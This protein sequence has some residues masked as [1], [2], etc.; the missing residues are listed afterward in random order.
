MT[1]GK[2]GASLSSGGMTPFTP[3]ESSRRRVTLK[4]QGRSGEPASCYRP[5]T[6]GIVEPNPLEAQ[7]DIDRREPAKAYARSWEQI[8]ALLCKGPYWKSKWRAHTPDLRSLELST[9]EDYRSAVQAS[10]QGETSS[11]TGERIEFWAESSGSTGQPKVYPW[12]A[13]F[14]QGYIQAS[15]LNFAYRLKEHP[16]IL[17]FGG[18]GLVG[19]NPHQ[20]SPGGVP[21]GHLSNHVFKATTP[22][23][24]TPFP[25]DVLDDEETADYWLPAFALSRD[26]AVVSAIIPRLH[27]RFLDKIETHR[28]EYLALLVGDQATPERFRGL[29]ASPERKALLRKVLGGT[30]PL[31]L[32]EL[33]PALELI[34]T[35]TSGSAALNLDELKDRTGDGVAICDIPYAATEGAFTII[36]S[37][38]DRG[39]TLHVGGEIMEFLP[40]GAEADKDNLVQAWDLQE[41]MLYEPVITTSM[42]VVR[43]R[44][45]DLLLCTGFEDRAPRLQFQGRVGREISIG[46]AMIGEMECIDAARKS[47]LNRGLPW[48]VSPNRTGNG[49]VIGVTEANASVSAEKFDAVM[50]AT[51]PMYGGFRE[52]KVL[53]A[54]RTVVLAPSHP[55]WERARPSHRQGKPRVLFEQS[56]ED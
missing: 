46:V 54:V 18:I 28:K 38:T 16:R 36:R 8:S 43:Y 3:T 20:T 9:F 31:K 33:W 41:G 11:L 24:I 47:G 21:V 55:I 19:L 22:R 49:L 48:V 39:G 40:Q 53:E 27:L 1:G 5:R 2:Q 23:D 17:E 37:E 6:E 4:N 56:I 44:M 34:T 26:L 35:W 10:Y 29:K 12:S 50:I 51:N 15:G 42:G 13:S 14:Q 7:F 30:G 25:F 52:K 32:K 45:H